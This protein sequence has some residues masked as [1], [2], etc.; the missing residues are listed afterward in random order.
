MMNG[1]QLQQFSNALVSAYPSA[2]KLKIALMVTMNVQLSHIVAPSQP[3]IT[4]MFELIGWAESRSRADELAGKL[5]HFNPENELLRK[6]CKTYTQAAVLASNQQDS[7]PVNK[8]KPSKLKLIKALTP[9]EVM[10]TEGEREALVKLLSDEAS[11]R[12]T[13]S[14]APRVLATNIISACLSTTPHKLE[15]LA[16]IMEILQDDTDAL[17]QFKKLI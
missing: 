1:Q 15:Q 17:Q 10:Q 12:V 13:W 16:E 8:P 6:Y 14:S 7:K 11:I 2:E 3:L 4:I 5:Q 9:C